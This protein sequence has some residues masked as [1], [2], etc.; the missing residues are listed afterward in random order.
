MQQ[1]PLG[2]LDSPGRRQPAN[3]GGIE[4]VFTLLGLQTNPV[5]IGGDACQR[6]RLGLEAQQL[7]MMAVAPGLPTQD[8]LRQ[9]RLAPDG[10]QS[11]GVQVLGMQ[12]PESHGKR[13]SCVD[14]SRR[15]NRKGGADCSSRVP[16]LLA[17]ATNDT[18]RTHRRKRDAT[19]DQGCRSGKA[20][21]VHSGIK[22]VSAC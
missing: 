14:G 1:L 8:R 20:R 18:T 2:L 6:I 12:G 16:V 4:A 13:T 7:R 17:K 22:Y 11:F 5:Q 15:H 10:N 21:V 3:A 19:G 9:Q